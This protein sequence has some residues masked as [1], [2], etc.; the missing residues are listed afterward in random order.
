M[1]DSEIKQEYLVKVEDEVYGPISEERLIEDLGKG[2]LSKDVNYRFAGQQDEQAKELAFLSKA[3]LIA[4]F[5][6]LVIIVTQFNSYSAPSV[7][8]LTVLLSLIGVFLGLVITQ[9][10]FVVIMTMIGIISLAGVVVNNAIV[11]IVF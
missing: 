11:L 9:Q 5:L 6:V 2:N 7:I 8:L 10:N 4:L 3:L 1:S